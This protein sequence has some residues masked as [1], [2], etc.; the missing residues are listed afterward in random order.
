MDTELYTEGAC[1]LGEGE[2][3]VLSEDLTFIHARMWFHSGLETSKWRSRV[4]E[5]AGLGGGGGAYDLRCN[6]WTVSYSTKFGDTGNGVG[7]S[8][9]QAL[10]V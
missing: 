5:P 4:L 1:N 8:L 7:D 6:I 3:R 10:L 9:W 2:W